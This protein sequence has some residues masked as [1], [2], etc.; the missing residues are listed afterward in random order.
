MDSGS[1]GLK[2]AP[3]E[4]RSWAQRCYHESLI[5]YSW[6]YRRNQ[7]LRWLFV[8]GSPLS[9]LRPSMLTKPAKTRSAKG[10]TRNAALLER[11]EDPGQNLPRNA[12]AGI[13]HPHEYSSL[14]IIGG[15]NANL[16]AGWREL[17]GILDDIPEHQLQT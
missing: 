2:A 9:P 15:D 3:T 7:M 5:G 8:A 4:R 12:D 6:D 17:H 1:F 13:N 10:P 11:I 14:T 16:P